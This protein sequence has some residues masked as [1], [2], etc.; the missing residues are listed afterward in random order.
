V[1]AH[2]HD[3][4]CRVVDRARGGR[5]TGAVAQEH[6]EI[7]LPEVDQLGSLVVRRARLRA[8]GGQQR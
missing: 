2:Q 7:Q 6:V 8:G 3:L 4:A 1:I 5:R